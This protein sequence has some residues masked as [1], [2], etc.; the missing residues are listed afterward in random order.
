MAI[1]RY[2]AFAGEVPRTDPHLLQEGQ[3][4]LSQNCDTSAGSV[5]PLNS[6]ALLSGSMQS[7]PVRG[8]YTEDGINFYTWVSETYAFK[9]PVIDDQFSR[10]YWLT[11]S[12][13]DFNV[14]TTLSMSS[15]G[16]TPI[17][18][19]TWRAGVPRP[20]AAPVLRLVPRITLP[21]YPN[22]SSLFSIWW[23]SN[24]QQYNVTLPTV[25]TYAG[26]PFNRWDLTLPSATG[27]P[28]GAVLVAKMEM[29]D[30]DNDDA[31]IFSVTLRAGSSSPSRVSALPGGIE[32]TLTYD[33]TGTPFARVDAKWGA[34]STRAYTY[35][36]ENSW[37]EEGPPAPP[38]T[39]APSYVQDVE[40]TVVAGDF[41]GRRPFMGYCFYR[42]FGTNPTY[43]KTDVTTVS[44]LVYKDEAR[45]PSAGGTALESHDWTPPPAGL[46][47]I[48]LMPNGWFAAYKGNVLY[49]SEPYRPHAWPYS[50]TFPTNIRGICPG[51]QSLVVTCAGGVYQVIGGFPASAQQMQL[52]VPQPG[53]A[54]RSMTSLD[55][56]VAYASND[57]IVLVNGT[58]GSTEASQ[59]LFTRDKWRSFYGDI[60]LDASIRLSYH[61]GFLVAS[62]NTQAKGFI[63]RMDD[64]PAT[65]TRTAER[66]DSAFQLPVTD[67]LYY[68]IGQSVYR[69]RGGAPNTL[70]W[71]GKDHVFS[72]Y[73]MF[74]AGY[75]RAD[76][77]VT[78]TVYADGTLYFT[79]TV[80]PGYFRLPGGRKALRWSVKLNSSAEIHELALASTMAELRDA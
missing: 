17:S 9:S 11:P 16:P 46:Q 14:S 8:I 22:T 29:V 40:I 33:T 73:E 24:G 1:I 80:Q 59:S 27:V 60:L 26:T 15:T 78:I 48:A 58:Q 30:V 28:A 52:S 18:G 75:L 70:T 32:F 69:F 54:Q 64:G 71:Q 74:G 76:G 37:N 43:I 61:D 51:Q 3:A 23:E 50:Q 65:Y 38:S 72:R 19:N 13:G 67:T 55:G 49:M 2:K 5:K 45:V 21:D 42:T 56:V 4:Q 79:G 35:T 77:P 36:Y 47:G 62:S 20:A 66:W 63:V 31:Q 34:E 39:I 53:I 6:G 68:S 7:N 44:A 10:M 12:S 25:T 57:G 41:T